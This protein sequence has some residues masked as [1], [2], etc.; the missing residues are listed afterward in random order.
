MSFNG[1]KVFRER[2]GKRGAC[3]AAGCVEEDL[4]AKA[5]ESPSGIYFELLEMPVRVELTNGLY[6][7]GGG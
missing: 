5:D 6:R 2:R 7:L 1:K 4:F 3:G